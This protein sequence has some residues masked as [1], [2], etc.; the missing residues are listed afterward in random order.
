MRFQCFYTIIIDQHGHIIAVITIEA[1]VII[2]IV[3]RAHGSRN[4]NIIESGPEWAATRYHSN[5]LG[6]EF[7][8]KYQFRHFLRLFFYAYEETMQGRIGVRFWIG[9]ILKTGS[10]DEVK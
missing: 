4:I 1:T 9:E 10:L 8:K 6:I 3:K 5:K 7:K 2:V